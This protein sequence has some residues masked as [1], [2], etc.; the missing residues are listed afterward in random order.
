MLS[1]AR[2]GK[3]P[4][5]VLLHAADPLS[6]AGARAQLADQKAIVLV[7]DR[8]YPGAVPLLVTGSADDE[9]VTRWGAGSTP[10]GPRAVL[11]TCRLRQSVLPN[12]V[13]RGIGAVVWRHDATGPRMARAVTAVARGE[14]DM[15]ADLVRALM[16]QISGLPQPAGRPSGTSALTAREVNIL[17]R[18]AEGDETG[19]IADRLG[20]SERTIKRDLHE[21]MKR[22]QLRTRAH[23]VAYAMR[24]GHL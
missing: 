2:S 9:M 17:R 24:T 15:P 4:I 3:P 23:A 6:E 22:L 20:Y 7:D 18:A 11:V 5:P 21:L 16:D 1:D 19:E 13:T 10:K 12:L 14:A 8:S